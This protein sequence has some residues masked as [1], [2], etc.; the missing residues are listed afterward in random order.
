MPSIIQKCVSMSQ[1]GD[2]SVQCMI[3]FISLSL[4]R[5]L[6][7]VYSYSDPPSKELRNLRLYSCFTLKTECP[8]QASIKKHFKMSDA[9]SD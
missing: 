3:E 5:Y 4:L 2:S 8:S 1:P 6:E 9:L 7:R